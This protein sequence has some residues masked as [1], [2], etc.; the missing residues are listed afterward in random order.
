MMQSHLFHPSLSLRTAQPELTFK[1]AV[2]SS[3]SKVL[4]NLHE[5]CDDQINNLAS[6]ITKG[7]F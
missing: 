2:F 5:L 6:H 7:A 1:P 4:Q 3:G